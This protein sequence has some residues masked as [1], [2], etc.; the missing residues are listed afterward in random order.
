MATT[1]IQKLLEEKLPENLVLEGLKNVFEL[2]GKDAI[3]SW[4]QTTTKHKQTVAHI[5]AQK[6]MAKVLEYLHSIGCDL[7]VQR[8]S[9]MGTPLHLAIYYQQILAIEKLRS[10]PGV[11]ASIKNS[12]GETCDKKFEE[13]REK[14][15]NMVWL[16][17]ELT[18]LDDTSDILEVAVIITDKNL[19]ELG[20]GQWV[21][22]HPKSVCDSLGEWHQKHFCAK[23]LGGNGLFADVVAS[24]LS[25]EQVE[26]QV[27]QLVKKHCPERSC[28]LA[29]SSVH[30][31]KEIIRFR[32][33][34]LYAYLNHRII[35]VST[36]Y[37]LMER[38]APK[39][40]STRPTT[41]GEGSAEH[42]AMSDIERSIALLKW[43]QENYLKPDVQ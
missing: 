18:S 3:N 23:E 37:G 39:L 43:S 25:R 9:D 6:N 1:T 32:M 19:K 13:L 5:A 40:L 41:I 42:R 4:R 2:H 12:Y 36:I 26:D 38:W 22:H 14:M 16:D 8:E 15:H 34:K 29:G 20:R 10:L 11:D 35:D 24:K 33:P 21:V 28:P 31:D 7:N 30:C 17:L 27:M